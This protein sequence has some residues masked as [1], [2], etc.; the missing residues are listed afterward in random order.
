MREIFFPNT[1]VVRL[2]QPENILNNENQLLT[3]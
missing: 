1:I 3:P 2:L